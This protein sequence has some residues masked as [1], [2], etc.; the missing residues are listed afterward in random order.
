M[1]N[2]RSWLDICRE[3]MTESSRVFGF[4]GRKPDV[5]KVIDL[6]DLAQYKHGRRCLSA[7]FNLKKPFAYNHH[8]HETEVGDVLGVVGYFV[9]NHSDKKGIPTNQEIEIAR[10]DF[11][12]EMDKMT[13]R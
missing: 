4:K 8:F 12:L 10:L 2:N 13:E 1:K 3:L 5:L 7:V 11:L 6:I 9:C